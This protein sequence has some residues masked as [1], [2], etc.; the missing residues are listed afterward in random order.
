[1]A[2]FGKGLKK[3]DELLSF[4]DDTL[5]N[6]INPN[7]AETWKILLVDDEQ[8]VHEVTR[9][10]LSDFSFENKNLNI[11]NAYSGKQAMSLLQEHPDI[12]VMLLDV[13]M[14]TDSAGLDVV[15][16]TREVLGYDQLRIILRTGQPGMTPEKQVLTKYDINDYRDKTDLTAQKLYTCVLS[17]LRNF[18]DLEKLKTLMNEKLAL[19][20]IADKRMQE[21]EG[22]NRA[23]GEALEKQISITEALQKSESLLDDAQRI[24]GIGCWEWDVSE[25]QITLSNRVKEYLDHDAESTFSNISDLY[26]NIESKDQEMLS[27]AISNVLNTGESVHLVHSVAHRDGSWLV[28]KHWIELGRTYSGGGKVILGT[29]QDITQQYIRNSEMRILSSAVKQAADAIFVTSYDGII[30]YV[31]PAFEKMTGYRSCEVVGNTSRIIRSDKQPDSYFKQMWSLLNSGRVFSDVIINKK[32][33]GDLYY[34]EKIITP[35]KDE[36]GKISHFISTGR[37]ISERM[38]TQQ[39]L[40]YMAHHDALTGLPNRSLLQDRLMQALSRTKHHN[41]LIAVLFLDL[42]RF[43]VI[44]DTLGHDV[45]DGLLQQM[46]E[47]LSGCVREGDTVSR[48][49]G[50]EFAILLNDVACKADVIVVTDKILK[51]LADPF[52]VGKHELYVTSS[53]GISLSPE[54]GNESVALLKKADMAMYKA[55]DNGKNNA[56]FY[57]NEDDSKALGKLSLETA[58]RKA[59]MNDEFYLM[60]QPQIDAFTGEMLGVEALLRW[61][62]E[63]Y[64]DLLPEDF[65]PLL[66]ESGLVVSVGEWVLQTACRQLES[67]TNQG[68]RNLQMSVNLSSRQFRLDT[69]VPM[70]KQILKNNGLSK[71]MLNLEITEGMLIEDIK[72]T[73]RCLNELRDA[74]VVISI[75]DFGTGYSSM[76]YL[77]ALPIDTIKIDKSFISR[78]PESSDDCSIVLGIITLA[79]SLGKKVVAEGVETVDQFEFLKSNKCDCIQGF[80]FSLPLKASDITDYFGLE[81]VEQ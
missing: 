31:N 48:L 1:M 39:R 41:R 23:L 81:G 19:Q 67:W 50:D 14:E 51:S 42:D 68:I 44:N 15:K 24:A 28:V 46:A 62:N 63:D 64:R 20:D 25:C 4:A 53:I 32:K 9:L 69:L 10:A 76:S 43:K 38:E 35:L 72:S 73:S 61:N 5:S 60:Y 13:V 33:N 6:P 54:N 75:D 18:Y 58:L 45:G 78:V 12:A 8:S 74:G 70:I 17:S 11:I 40:L 36:K 52:L 49:G 22:T 21:V 7:E 77:K 3:S 47:R 79:H 16:Y 65:I 27:S 59:L 37:D 30:E 66:E 71:D 57:T 80:L 55:K 2:S 29:M 34:E 26:K 56:Q